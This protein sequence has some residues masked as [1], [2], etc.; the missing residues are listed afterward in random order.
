MIVHQQRKW[1]HA[2]ASPAGVQDRMKIGKVDD[3]KIDSARNDRNEYDNQMSEEDNVRRVTNDLLTYPRIWLDEVFVK[4]RRDVFFIPGREDS[5]CKVRVIFVVIRRQ[6][7]DVCFVAFIVVV[8]V[9]SGSTVQLLLLLV[10]PC[11]DVTE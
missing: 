8:L 3:V 11:F 2:K 10:L 7:L 5:R 9:D 1:P 4:E 6:Q